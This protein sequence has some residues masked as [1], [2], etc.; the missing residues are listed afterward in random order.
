MV[1]LCS[2]NAA[3]WELYT[4]APMIATLWGATALWFVVWIARDIRR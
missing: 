4:E 3:L 2:I 1:L